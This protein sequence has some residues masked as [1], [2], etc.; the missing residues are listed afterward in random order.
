M[1]NMILI[2][3][4]F[5][6]GISN[7]IPGVS[8][9]TLMMSLGVFEDVIESVSHFFKNKKKHFMFLLYIFIGAILS[10]VLMSRVI[11][12][13]LD[14]F[15][16]P[17]IIFFV[18]LILGG[19]PMLISNVKS[20]KPKLINFII[21]TITFSIV[22]IF[23]LLSSNSANIS[24]TNMNLF[25]YILLCLVG[26]VAAVSMVVPGLSGSFM[27]ILFGY[28]EPLMNTIK[29]FTSFNNI[30]SNGIIL[31]VFGIGVLLGIFIMIKAIEYLLNKY[32]VN[33]YYGIL[34]F[35]V[36]SIYAILNTMYIDGFIA[37]MGHVLCAV[38]LFIV[39]FFIS[40]KLGEK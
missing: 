23:S 22:I 32:K 20:E 30:I 5:I 7:I 34:G 26:L 8:G 13:S 17:T 28:Y 14:N 15:K 19:L 21:F 25:S 6:I 9:G 35:V 1:K 12:Y 11:T 2:I 37:S 10:I 3:K 40:F 24:F 36:S 18:G 39:G 16:L 29:D 31:F 33:T 27:L 38:V 4:G